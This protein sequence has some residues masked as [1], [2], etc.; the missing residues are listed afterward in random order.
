MYFF[1]FLSQIYNFYGK[2]LCK[3]IIVIFAE[4]QCSIIDPGVRG[5][6]NSLRNINISYLHIIYYAF[7]VFDLYIYYAE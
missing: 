5:N 6:R 2:I 4:V 3:N 1:Y 7:I